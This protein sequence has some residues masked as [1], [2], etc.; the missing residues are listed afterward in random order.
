MLVSRVFVVCCGVASDLNLWTKVAG[1]CV[2]CRV[3]VFVASFFLL[4]SLGFVY[5]STHGHP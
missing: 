1:L 3:D 2:T 4:L 5:L